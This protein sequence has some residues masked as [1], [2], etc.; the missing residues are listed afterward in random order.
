MKKYRV[1]A[2]I[3]YRQLDN[4]EIIIKNVAGEDIVDAFNKVSTI[5]LGERQRRAKKF[6]L[7]VKEEG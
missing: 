7:S 4:E 3:A 5:I 1:M 2:A 6:T